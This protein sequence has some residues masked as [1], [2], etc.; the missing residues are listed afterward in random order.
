MVTYQ[1]LPGM[2]VMTVSDEPGDSVRVLEIDGRVAELRNV[3]GKPGQI[4]VTYVER[5][6]GPDPGGV[7]GVP[8]ERGGDALPPDGGPEEAG[9]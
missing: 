8:P 4:E 7:P 1:E 6:G 2:K 9:R 3:K 5:E